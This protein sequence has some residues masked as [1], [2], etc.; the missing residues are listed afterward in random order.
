MPASEFHEWDA[1]IEL[2]GPVHL[3]GR[4]DQA[5]ALMAFTVSTVNGGK[6]PYGKFLHYPPPP[7][8]DPWEGMTDV[9]RQLLEAFNQPGQNEIAR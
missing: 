3:H 6:T 4:L 8:V 9:D 2:Y 5:G 1:Y 7:A